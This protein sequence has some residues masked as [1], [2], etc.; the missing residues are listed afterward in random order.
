MVKR[1]D[2]LGGGV[3]GGLLAGLSGDTAEAGDAQQRP[4]QQQMDDFTGV[5]EAIDKL[6]QEVAAGR[7]FTEIAAVR[8]A[9]RIFLRSNHHLPGFIEVGTTPWFNAYDWHVRWQQPLNLGRDPLG[10]Y[11]LIFQ[12]TTLI[13]RSDMP[14]NFMSLPFD[15]R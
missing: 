11:T 14:E 5:V 1:R 15:E 10:R 4:R 2:L 13:M 12:G 7:A 9:Q 6:R 3:L 8:E